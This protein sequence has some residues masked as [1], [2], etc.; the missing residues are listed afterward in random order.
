MRHGGGGLR[1]SLL[2]HLGSTP[3]SSGHLSIFTSTALVTCR[4]GR[5]LKVGSTGS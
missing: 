5:G 1:G 2:F 3:E 4:D